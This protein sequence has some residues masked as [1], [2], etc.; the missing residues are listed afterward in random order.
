MKRAVLL[1]TSLWWPAV[2]LGQTSVLTYHNDNFRTGQNTQETILNL[3]NVRTPNRFAR[4]FIQPVDGEV[5][6]QPLYVPNVTMGPHTP[7]AGTKHNVLFV[8]TQDDMVYAF[9]A[10]NREGPNAFPLWQA[11]MLDPARGAAAG[12]TAVPRG[13]VG[14]CHDIDPQIGITSTPAI[15]IPSGTLYVV[16]KSKEV[17]AGVA[18][19]ILRLHALAITNGAERTNSPVVMGDTTESSTGVYT[20]TTNIAV[21]G[22]GDG[23][24][25]TTLSFN[26]MRQNQRAGL[27]VENGLVYVASGSHCDVTPYHGWIVAYNTQTLAQAAVFCTTPNGYQGGIWMAGAGLAADANGNL[28]I[29]V[30]NGTFDTTLDPQGLPSNRDFGDSIVKLDGTL[31]PLDYFTPWNQ[32][33]MGGPAD[34]D[35]GSGGVLLIPDQPGSHPHLLT[36]A[37]KV[38]TIYLVDRDNM[39]HYCSG[40]TAN[41]NILQE[42]LNGVANTPVPIYWNGSVYFR[43]D[44]DVLK[45]F[46]LNNGVLTAAPRSPTDVY[47]GRIVISSN[48]IQDGIVWS[49]KTDGFAGGAPAVLDAYD[50]ASFSRLYTSGLKPDDDPGKAVRFSS[51]IVANG[52]V[53]VEAKSQV[54]VFGL[55]T[56]RV[57]II[58]RQRHGSSW[59][60]TA[61]AMDT[62][63]G[64]PLSGTVDV[65]GTVVGQTNHPFCATVPLCTPLRGCWSTVTVKLASFPTKQFRIIIR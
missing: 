47:S 52:R 21:P 11:S 34:A 25:G 16:A 46:S 2:A 59:C 10:E 3:A 48:G 7:Q 35:L 41:T 44:L 37:G 55:D 30:G 57:Q 38:D 28:F 13:D 39:G 51:P 49:L 17:V 50:A 45:A 60:A 43:G 23:S 32:S 4:L 63:T 19:Y 27:L 36:Q 33:Y 62:A 64:R 6:A 12:A 61:A 65:N 54:A 29:A 58:N 1:L 22:T 26:A 24:N 18:H 9:D 56:A 5:Y 15:D 31:H 14:W 40:C 42:I 20:N 53:Y 8:A